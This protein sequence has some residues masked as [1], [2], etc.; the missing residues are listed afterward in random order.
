MA[1]K[2]KE[3]MSDEEFETLKATVAEEEQRRIEIRRQER[4]Q[5]LDRINN[6]LRGDRVEAMRTDMNNILQETQVKE[7]RNWHKAVQG[8]VTAIDHAQRLIPPSA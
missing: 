2:D 8:V 4:D 7:N 6:V 1:K 5:T 3:P